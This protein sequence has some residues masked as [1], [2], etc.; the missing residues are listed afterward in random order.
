[1][2][3]QRWYSLRNIAKM[4]IHITEFIKIKREISF[5]LT[6]ISKGISVNR[7][8]L[9]LLY[10]DVLIKTEIRIEAIVLSVKVDEICYT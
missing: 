1:M 9:F 10:K 2:I 4:Y 8:S 7:S 5:Q 6:Q 3:F